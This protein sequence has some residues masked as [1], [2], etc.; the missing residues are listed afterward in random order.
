MNTIYGLVDPRT[1]MLRYVGVTRQTVKRR[2]TDHI[3][4]SRNG[5]A[6][7]RSNWIR[8]VLDEG[9][10]PQTIVLEVTEDRD[11]EIIWIA[12]F[13]SR[14]CELT[15]ST[16]GGEGVI[17]LPEEI[18][19]QI[20]RKVTG[21]KHSAEAREKIREASKRMWQNPEIKKH[22]ISVNTGKK[23][24]EDFGQRMSDF[25]KGNQYRLGHT[26]SPE[27]RKKSADS[28]R[29]KARQGH[30]H[31]EAT[32]AHLRD[33]ATGRLHSEDTKRKISE[34]Q[35]GKKR[36]P[37]S[38]EHIA[39]LTKAWETRSVRTA[40]EETRKKIA[41][42]LTGGKMSPESIEKMRTSQQARRLRESQSKNE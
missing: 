6:T 41:A 31:T 5:E 22:I 23:R 15:N 28:Q 30:P 11:R 26:N 32:K 7:Y 35:T 20:R 14:G 27:H 39:N 9:L 34:L 18:R 33:I 25:H 19:E 29:G 13:R 36:G 4:R 42:T 2:L 12:F 17:N 24:N 10:E 40:S 38:E 37:F 8:S 21:F 16:D 3:K 1:G